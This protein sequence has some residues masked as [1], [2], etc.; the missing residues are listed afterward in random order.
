MDV[1]SLYWTI[2][3]MTFAEI[4]AASESWT[5]EQMRKVLINEHYNR[6]CRDHAEPP[7]EREDEFLHGKAIP[8]MGW[9]WRSVDFAGK[10]IPIGF[11]GGYVA[12]MANNKWDHHERYLTEAEADQLL[13]LLDAAIIESR[14]G[15]E[16]SEIQ[17]K[18]W[19]AVAKIGPWM[20]G[21]PRVLAP[22]S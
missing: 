17:R 20:Q 22:A 16:L 9:F 12:I 18:T 5:A 21:L 4:K 8:Y 19:D 1:S 7:K 3:K 6:F 11:S 10:R 13:A 2:N 14:Q 15:G